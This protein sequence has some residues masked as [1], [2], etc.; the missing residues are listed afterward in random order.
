[1]VFSLFQPFRRSKTICWVVN[2]SLAISRLLM[3]IPE[4]FS[5]GNKRQRWDEFWFQG[6]RNMESEALFYELMSQLPE[7]EESTSGNI[8][9]GSY[10]VKRT[11]SYNLFSYNPG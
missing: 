3:L 6:V 9:G 5:H 10:H 11:H 2:T 7:N 4:T 8:L 1:M